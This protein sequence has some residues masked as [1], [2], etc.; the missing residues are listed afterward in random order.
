VSQSQ[1]VLLYCHCQKGFGEGFVGSE[2]REA[3]C[4]GPFGLVLFPET[5]VSRLL[6]RVKLFLSGYGKRESGIV[7]PHN[8]IN[9]RTGRSEVT[10]HFSLPNHA[11]KVDRTFDEK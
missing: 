7:Y 8:G 10:G 9:E 5:T 2:N 4:D 11:L 6:L 3:H 1:T